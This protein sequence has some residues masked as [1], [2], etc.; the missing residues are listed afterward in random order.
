MHNQWIKKKYAFFKKEKSIRQLKK[1]LYSADINVH[2]LRIKTK[3]KKK[4]QVA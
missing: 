3:G 2:I 4:I 1:K